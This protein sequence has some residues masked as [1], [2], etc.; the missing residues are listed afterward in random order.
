MS[1][2]D[3]KDN[4]KPRKPSSS[5]ND[6]HLAGGGVASVL[7]AVT[8]G[9]MDQQMSTWCIEESLQFKRAADLRA[10]RK[11]LY[12]SDTNESHIPHVSGF[13]HDYLAELENGEKGNGGNALRATHSWTYV[14]VDGSISNW[15]WVANRSDDIKNKFQ[16][17]GENRARIVVARGIG[18]SHRQSNSGLGT[19]KFANLAVGT[20]SKPENGALAY[21]FLLG[22]ELAV[23]DCEGVRIENHLSETDWISQV[24]SVSFRG[25]AD[26]SV[27]VIPGDLAEIPGR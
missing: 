19:V 21:T 2:S 22:V 26:G 1:M 3:R 10:V 14:E 24:A 9:K 18:L 15:G 23:R 11:F 7:D 12:A 17:T 6:A 16:T 27:K 8:Q 5:A 4:Q 25:S 13:V 20:V